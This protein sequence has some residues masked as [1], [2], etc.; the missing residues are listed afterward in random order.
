MRQSQLAIISLKRLKYDTLS[1]PVGAAD[2]RSSRGDDGGGGLRDDVRDVRPRSLW[3]RAS[4]RIASTLDRG[5]GEPP[6][7]AR[8]A[9]A[10][11]S[12]GQPSVESRSPAGRSPSTRSTDTLSVG[13]S[14]SNSASASTQPRRS[15]SSSD[16]RPAGGR[17]AP[18]PSGASRTNWR[19]S[20]SGGR[21][22]S[23]DPRSSSLDSWAAYLDGGAS[24]LSV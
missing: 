7:S 18:D 17:G 10:R 1:A 3:D 4:A 6:S 16:Q 21:P 22:L 19:S 20:Y 15:A 8:R 24:V 12:R 23:K 11:T 13:S 14:I 9:K 2:L 5:G